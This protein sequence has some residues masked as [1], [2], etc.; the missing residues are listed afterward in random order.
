[1]V[2]K[3]IMILKLNECACWFPEAEMVGMRLWVEV[4]GLVEAARVLR[5]LEVG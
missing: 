5:T 2:N 1:M 3:V 4:G